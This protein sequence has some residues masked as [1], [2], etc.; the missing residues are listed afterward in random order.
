MNSAYSAVT[1]RQDFHAS[2]Q[3]IWRSKRCLIDG[4]GQDVFV[5]NAGPGSGSGSG[6]DTIQDFKQ[7]E[8]TLHINGWTTTKTVT[9]ML[10]TNGL[11]VIFDTA[12]MALTVAIS[13]CLGRRPC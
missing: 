9:Q 7:G 8:D 6:S 1:E 12:V 2:K 11:V 13:P 3:P 5:L 10:Q 4:N